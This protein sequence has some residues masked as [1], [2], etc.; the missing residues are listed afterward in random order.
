[1]SGSWLEAGFVGDLGGEL[2]GAGDFAG[3]G[4]LAGDFAA[5]LIVAVAEY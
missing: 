5:S 2:A 4:D 3:D 1:M